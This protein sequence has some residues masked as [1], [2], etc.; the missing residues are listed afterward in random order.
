MSQ[1]SPNDYREQ[2]DDINTGYAIS[3]QQVIQ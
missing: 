1:T 2:L 3:L